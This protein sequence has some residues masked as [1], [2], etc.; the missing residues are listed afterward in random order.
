M[1][2]NGYAMLVRKKTKTKQ[3]PY[4]FFAFQASEI[5]ALPATTV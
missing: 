4:F 1:T 5:L 3:T 2:H